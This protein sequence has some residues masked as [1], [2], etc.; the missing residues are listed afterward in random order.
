M[1]VRIPLPSSS[2]GCIRVFTQAMF[3]FLR[4][5]PVGLVGV[6]EAVGQLTI[7]IGVVRVTLLERIGD[8]FRLLLLPWQGTSC[9]SSSRLILQY[10]VTASSLRGR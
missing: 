8:E 4:V 2:L 9:F 5:Q 6:V 10:E 1:S 7:V 3:K